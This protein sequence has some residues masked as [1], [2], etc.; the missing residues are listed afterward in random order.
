M[1]PILGILA[2]GGLITVVQRFFLACR[3]LARTDAE[4]ERAGELPR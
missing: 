3:A 2:V 1:V 4:N